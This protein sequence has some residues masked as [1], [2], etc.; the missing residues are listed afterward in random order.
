[1]LAASSLQAQIDFSADFEGGIPP[2]LFPLAGGGGAATPFT[3][4]GNG[5]VSFTFPGTAPFEVGEVRL[6]PLSTQLDFITTVDVTNFAGGGIDGDFVDIGLQATLFRPNAGSLAP[7]VP[8]FA[9]FTS[10]LARSTVENNAVVT[11]IL[12]DY[13]DSDTPLSS[14]LENL[15]I[16]ASGDA[17]QITTVGINYDASAQTITALGIDQNLAGPPIFQEFG[18]IHLG[19]A[20]E[21]LQITDE[22]Q[23]F[24][25]ITAFQSGGIAVAEGD[26]SDP[27]SF[28]VTADNFSVVQEVPEPSTVAFAFGLMAGVLVWLRR[29]PRG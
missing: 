27:N 12:T 15:I 24:V 2:G 3:S 19:A 28:L 23:W 7:G 29:R 1:M 6:G 13:G 14:G 9:Q 16:G 17:N 22:D 11:N 8:T 5:F 10:L 25:S 4:G 20:G 18:T 26:V 21:D